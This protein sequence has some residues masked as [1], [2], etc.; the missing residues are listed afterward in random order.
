MQADRQSG[1]LDGFFDSIPRARRV[2]QQSSRRKPPGPENVDDRLIDR[3]SQPKIVSIDNDSLR[4]RY[5]E[6]GGS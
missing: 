5:S 3:I 2:D 6:R 1:V 4:H